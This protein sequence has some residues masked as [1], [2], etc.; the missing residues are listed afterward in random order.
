MLWL[1][2]KNVVAKTRA[3]FLL[4]FVP[5]FPRVFCCCGCFASCKTS[6][7]FF[8][9]CCFLE[10]WLCS[11]TCGRAFLGDEM[12]LCLC[13]W[14]ANTKTWFSPSPAVFFFLVLIFFATIELFSDLAFLLLCFL[15]RWPGRFLELFARFVYFFLPPFTLNAIRYHCA[16]LLRCYCRFCCRAGPVGRVSFFSW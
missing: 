7:V 16:F 11:F 15:L 5:F 3:G 13:L 14:L 9:Q 1:H 4:L 2:K 8:M 10:F 6:V 12:S